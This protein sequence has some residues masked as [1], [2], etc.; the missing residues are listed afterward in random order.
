MKILDKIRNIFKIKPTWDQAKAKV[1]KELGVSQAQIFAWKSHLIV[2]IKPEENIVVLQSETGKIINII[3][4]SETKKNLLKGIS[5]NQFLPKYGTDFI[6]EIRSWRFS[7]SRTKPTEYKVDLRA[8]LK[9]E[10]QIT[11]KRKK[12]YHKRNVIVTVFFIK[13][14]IEKT[15]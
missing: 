15:I 11:E 8:R 2:E 10:D 4:D 7:Y 3:L 13:N 14:L 12:M 5:E 1:H 6:N 9:P